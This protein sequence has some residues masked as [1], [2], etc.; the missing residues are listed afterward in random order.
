VSKI[1]TTHLT[2]DGCVEE[3]WNTL[4][5]LSGYRSW[6]PFIPPPPAPSTSGTGWT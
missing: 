3:V 6:N 1:I 5:D 4:T 2:I